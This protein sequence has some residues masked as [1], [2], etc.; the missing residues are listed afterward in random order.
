MGWMPLSRT[1]G[2]GPRQ[3]VRGVLAARQRIRKLREDPINRQTHFSF[4][5]SNT[6]GSTLPVRF[7]VSQPR[8]R[9]R[10]H[11]SCSETRWQLC[12]GTKP[13][14]T[15]QNRPALGSGIAP[16]SQL[17]CR[18]E[19][20]QNVGCHNN[21]SEIRSAAEAV[22]QVE[23]A[24]VKQGEREKPETMASAAWVAHQN[25]REPRPCPGSGTAALT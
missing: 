5:S 4:Y 3:R 12:G 9:V 15:T 8:A 10:V 13:A 7:V 14:G 21:A 1:S 2:A 24:C 11:V 23:R 22:S 25:R 20:Y 17:P 18:P 19:R 16:E 6:T